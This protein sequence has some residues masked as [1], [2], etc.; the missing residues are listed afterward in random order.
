MCHCG[1]TSPAQ[2]PPANIPEKS[3]SESL[4]WAMDA[5]AHSNAAPMI[6]VAHAHPQLLAVAALI[7]N[8]TQVAYCVWLI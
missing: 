8:F 4:N 3:G 7:N 2:N 5:P 1:D 6:R